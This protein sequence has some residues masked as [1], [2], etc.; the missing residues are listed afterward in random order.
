VSILDTP[1]SA[2]NGVD[3]NNEKVWKLLK[4]LLQSRKIAPKEALSWS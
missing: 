1:Y 2:R 4:L 3:H